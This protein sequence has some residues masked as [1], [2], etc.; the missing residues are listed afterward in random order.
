VL[1]GIAA[2]L[3]IRSTQRTSSIANVTPSLESCI[4]KNDDETGRMK[5]SQR[6]LSALS[7]PRAHAKVHQR[8]ET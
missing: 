4:D 2:Q 6:I 7:A 8:L 5:Q 3:P 1:N